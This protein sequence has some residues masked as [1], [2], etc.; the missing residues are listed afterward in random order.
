MYDKMNSSANCMEDHVRKLI[1]ISEYH[2]DCEN[3]PLVIM[4][5]LKFIKV[6][7]LLGIPFMKYWDVGG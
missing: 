1:F 3:K 2:V 5:L 6:L 7:L 4:R